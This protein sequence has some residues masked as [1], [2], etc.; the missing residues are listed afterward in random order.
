M[1][2][3]FADRLRVPFGSAEY[4]HI[5]ERLQRCRKNLDNEIKNRREELFQKFAIDLQLMQSNEKVRM[6]NS[7]KTSK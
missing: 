6:L 2:D 3:L 5:E 4:L 7:I 1:E